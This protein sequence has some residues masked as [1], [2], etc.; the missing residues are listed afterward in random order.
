MTAAIYSLRGG[1]STLIIEKSNFGGQ[2]ANSPRVEN[3]PGTKAISGLEFSDN[4][5]QELNS[6]FDPEIVKFYEKSLLLQTVDQMWKEHLQALDFL[7]RSIG[8][9]AYG[10]RDP[11]VEYKRESFALFESMLSRVTATGLSS[12]YFTS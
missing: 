5:T 8:L 9:R 4:L 6:K 11:L 1:K 3:I 10:Q 12:R 2:I 7:K